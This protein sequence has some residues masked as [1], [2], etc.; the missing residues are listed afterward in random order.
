MR[1]TVTK[2]GQTVIPAAVRRQFNI[3]SSDRLEWI[4]ENNT[5]RVVPVKKDPID[6]FRGKGRGGATARLLQ[7]RAADLESE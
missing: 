6:A 4:V 1:S 3:T 7:E 2:R 5:I